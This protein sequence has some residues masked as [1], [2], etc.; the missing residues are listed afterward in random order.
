MTIQPLDPHTTFP[1]SLQESSREQLRLDR[2]I[3]NQDHLMH[4]DKKKREDAQ[5]MPVELDE[6]QQKI[7]RHREKEQGGQK[8]K[9]ERQGGG[10]EKTEEEETREP[11]WESERGQ[12]FDERI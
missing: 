11:P 9:K 6:L 3:L 1:R 8:R 4:V 5:Q 7:L 10:S 12:I 2:P